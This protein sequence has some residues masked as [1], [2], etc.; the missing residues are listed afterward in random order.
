MTILTNGEILAK[1]KYEIIYSNKND[2]HKKIN[3]NN[4]WQRSAETVNLPDFQNF[5]HK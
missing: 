1:T 4:C 5:S 2:C 3:S